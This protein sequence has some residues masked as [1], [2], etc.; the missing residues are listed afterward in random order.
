MEVRFPCLFGFVGKKTTIR[1]MFTD[2]SYK[3]PKTL[4]ILKMILDDC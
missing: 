3:N 2:N 1:M 4:T